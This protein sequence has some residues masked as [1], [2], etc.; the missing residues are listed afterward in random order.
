MAQGKPVQ[1]P[2]PEGDL[3][4]W[5]VGAEGSTFHAGPGCSWP[6]SPALRLCVFHRIFQVCVHRKVLL[7]IWLK[8]LG[9]S[10]RKT[11]SFKGTLPSLHPAGTGMAT[12]AERLEERRASAFRELQEKR[13]LMEQHRR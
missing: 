13:A 1:S 2:Q 6:R 12:E 5:G 11:H 4:A 8:T 9:N 10:R 3:A 7:G